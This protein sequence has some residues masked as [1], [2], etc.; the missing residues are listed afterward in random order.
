MHRKLKYRNTKNGDREREGPGMAT[1]N[2]LQ[3]RININLVGRNTRPNYF[4]TTSHL[5][6]R[7]ENR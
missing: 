1:I 2:E 6:S 5:S 3:V 7:T 4:T